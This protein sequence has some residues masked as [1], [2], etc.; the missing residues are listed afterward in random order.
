MRP[1]SSLLLVFVTAVLL[2]ACERVRSIP[3]GTPAP[4]RESGCSIDYE[5]V[6]PADAQSRWRQVGDVCVSAGSGSPTVQDFYS[7]GDLRDQLNDEACGLGGE[8]VTPVGLC[9]NRKENGIEFG[10]YVPRT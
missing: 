5:Q 10:V 1:W 2:T 7:S 9:A 8:I 4:A 6:T 3:I